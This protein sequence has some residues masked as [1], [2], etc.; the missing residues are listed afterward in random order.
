MSLTLRSSVTWPFDSPSAFSYCWSFVTEPL[1]PDVFEVLSRKHIG[2]TTTTFQSHV[3]SSITIRFPIG[4]FIFASSDRRLV[5]STVYPQYITSQ[6]TDRQTPHCGISAA[7]STVGSAI[8]VPREYIKTK[9]SV[10]AVWLQAAVWSKQAQLWQ[11][12][13]A[14]C[15]RVVLNGDVSFTCN[16]H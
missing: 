15:P 11:P 7:V 5:T 6:T 4:H 1:S 9:L 10:A 12:H 2:V 8:N 3:T 14:M 16:P 13:R